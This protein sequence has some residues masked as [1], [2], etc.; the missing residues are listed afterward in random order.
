MS[1]SSQRMPPSQ[2]EACQITLAS[3]YQELALEL[4]DRG[5]FHYSSPAG[6]PHRCLPQAYEDAK[7]T[8]Q[9][10]EQTPAA[11]APPPLP[12]RRS[13][14]DVLKYFAEEG[15]ETGNAPDTPK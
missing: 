9:I 4:Q 8:L 13:F 1:R 12:K 6:S 10:L 5:R 3:F 2:W 11:P 7:A 14:T 15:D